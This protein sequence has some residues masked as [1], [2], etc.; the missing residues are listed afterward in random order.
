MIG[1]MLYIMAD[2]GRSA[3]LSGGACDREDVDGTMRFVL[4]LLRHGMRGR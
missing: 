4:P 1:T 2:A 3:H